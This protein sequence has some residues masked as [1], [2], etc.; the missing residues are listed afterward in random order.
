[1]R[2]A[3]VQEAVGFFLSSF[4]YEGWKSCDLD[5]PASEPAAGWMFLLINS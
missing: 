1:M 3:A 5:Q 2:G 4:D